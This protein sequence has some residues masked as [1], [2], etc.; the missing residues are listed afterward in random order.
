MQDELQENIP[1]S[2][3]EENYERPID[4]QSRMEEKD[5]AITLNFAKGQ[6]V[7]YNCKISNKWCDAEVVDVHFDD[8]PDEPYYTI[9][10][11]RSL[12]AAESAPFETIEKQTTACRLKRLEDDRVELSEQANQPKLDKVPSKIGEI[13]S[14]DCYNFA[15]GQRAKY[16][17]NIAN[18]WCDAQIRAVH[19][20]DGSTEPYYTIQYGRFEVELDSVEFKPV[21]KQTTASRLMHLPIYAGTRTLLAV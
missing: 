18:Q 16:Y 9:K 13:V 3:K 1:L 21:E 20:D 12:A 6:H 2:K 5:S 11:Q 17:C 7:L 19:S 8:G 15:K 4:T 14:V 10:F